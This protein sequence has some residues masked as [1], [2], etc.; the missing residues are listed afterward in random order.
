MERLITVVGIG[1]LGGACSGFLG[2]GGGII[3]APLLLYVPVWLGQPALSMHVVGGLTI[4][5][6][7]CAGL[8]GAVAHGRRH[9]VDRKL[10]VVMGSAI[11]AASLV[12]AA[13]SKHFSHKFLLG[14]FTVLALFAALL[15]FLPRRDADRRDYSFGGFSFWGAVSTALAV[16]VLGGLVG[17]SGSFLLIPA[18]ATGLKVPLRVA[19]GSNMV[20]VFF[21]SLAG[22]IGKAAT[23]QIPPVLALSLLAGIVPGALLG[24]YFSH[25]VPVRALR[26]ALG[27]LIVIACGR[28][29]LDLAG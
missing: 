10:A 11:F 4:T 18:V 5:Q 26:L 19:M 8:V 7:L 29:A 22:F 9:A 17:Q 27:C 1:L 6:S 12:G 14:V 24:S 21:A 20:I 16:G 3:S 25:R 13:G 15:I 28:M 23:G 2:I